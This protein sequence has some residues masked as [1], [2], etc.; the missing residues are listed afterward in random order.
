MDRI[1]AKRERSAYAAALDPRPTFDPMKNLAATM[2]PRTRLPN[3]R[4]ANMGNVT[5]TG[6]PLLTYTPK[7]PIYA[8]ADFAGA[9]LDAARIEPALLVLSTGADMPDLPFSAEYSAA[10]AP[11]ERAGDPTAA[12]PP[13]ELHAWI[14]RIPP[15]ETLDAAHP[16]ARR[17]ST[18]VKRALK[19]ASLPGATAPL[20]LRQALQQPAG[21]RTFMAP[22]DTGPPKCP[23]P[24][25]ADGSKRKPVVL[26][27]REGPRPSS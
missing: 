21:P 13:L 8:V 23:K 3:F 1:W 7:L 2:S 18:E 25:P 5:F 27:A 17:L 14:V 26:E 12:L 11:R 15:V 22:R 6:Y 10:R 4:C 16:G 19:H 9:R 20:W 24:P